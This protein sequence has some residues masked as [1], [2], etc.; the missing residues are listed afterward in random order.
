MSNVSTSA[1]EHRPPTSSRC[2]T[3]SF[4]ST[5]NERQL[6]RKRPMRRPSMNHTRARKIRFALTQRS[7][8]FSTVRHSGRVNFTS[9]HLCM[10]CCQL[11]RTQPSPMSAWSFVCVRGAT[12]GERT[13]PQR[14]RRIPRFEKYFHSKMGKLRR[15]SS[16]TEFDAGENETR[17]LAKFCYSFSHENRSLCARISVDL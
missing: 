11:Q 2:S 1:Q 5:A 15:S 10:Y 14:R 16:H 12:V 3:M 7:T 9:L 13:P 4:P 6:H 17:T 8:W